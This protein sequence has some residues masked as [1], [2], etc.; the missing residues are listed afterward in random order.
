MGQLR[1]LTYN[2]KL[3]PDLGRSALKDAPFVRGGVR[4]F[5]KPWWEEWMSD[6]ARTT[7]LVKALA[8]SKHDVICLQEVFDEDRRKQ[9]RNGLKRADYKHFVDYSSDH[10]PIHEDSGLFLASRHPIRWEHFEE[11][12]D[13]AGDDALADKGI[14]CVSL[15]VGRRL[16]Q[17][18][19]IVFHTHMQAYNTAADRSARG[20]QIEQLGR[21]ISRVAG[22]LRQPESCAMVV[23][24]DFNIAAERLVDDELRPT[25]E[26]TKLKRFLGAHR[27]L[28]RTKNRKNPGYTSD[29][30]VNKKM[31]RRRGAP[32]GSR[33]DYVFA[34]DAV[35][36][37][38]GDIDRIALRKLKCT[39]AGVEPFFDAER[40]GHLSDHFG[41]SVPLE[42]AVGRRR[43]ARSG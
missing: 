35:T 1:L 20:K 18:T 5:A 7:R 4:Q 26:Y 23:C 29:S 22:K 15:N 6:K 34:L 25:R 31:M 13:N 27:D 14:S 8:A 2:V 30:R 17:T 36:P 19:L 37:I 40:D 12:A 28:Y 42:R 24:G 33:I 41:V 11:Y 16:A 21:K 32:K 10:D 38:T 3:L 43:R 9:L 39:R